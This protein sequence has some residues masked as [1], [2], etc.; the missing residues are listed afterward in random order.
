MISKEPLV[1][2]LYSLIVGLLLYIVFRFIMSYTDHFAQITAIII[3]CFT[4]V[5]LLLFY[6]FSQLISGLKLIIKNN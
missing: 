4:C 2:V 1:Y 6:E 5:Y 3:S